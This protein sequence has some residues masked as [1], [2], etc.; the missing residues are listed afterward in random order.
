M[1]P[2]TAS[3]VVVPDTTTSTTSETVE[4]NL[5]QI[6]SDQATPHKYDRTLVI[7]AVIGAAVTF[8]LC[9]C[10]TVFLAMYC[11]RKRRRLEQG[12]KVM[13]CASHKLED[14]DLDDES[15]GVMIGKAPEIM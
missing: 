3:P 6:G 10:V 8:V 12:V 15:S 5:A 7:G 9:L 11:W 14:M 1:E 2:T 4:A 13:H